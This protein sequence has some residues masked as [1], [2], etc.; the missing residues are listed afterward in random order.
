MLDNDRIDLSERI[1]VD[2]KGTSKEYVICHY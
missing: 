2:K 1:D